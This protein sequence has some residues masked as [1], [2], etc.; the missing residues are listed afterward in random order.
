MGSRGDNFLRVSR[1][2]IFCS[3]RKKDAGSWPQAALAV[4]VLY[5]QHVRFTDNVAEAFPARLPPMRTDS[6]TLV[7]G[8]AGS[9][10]TQTR[11]VDRTAA[12]PPP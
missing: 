3:A 2:W 11:A 9:P 10:L 6:P 1:S 4:P 7:V 5:P 12:N 8:S